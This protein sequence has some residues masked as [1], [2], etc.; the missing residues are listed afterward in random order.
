MADFGVDW[1]LIVVVVVG[2]VGFL[3][4]ALYAVVRAQRSKQPTGAPGL[5]GKEAQVRTA[6]D[7]R[8][9][10]MVHG[11]LWE[12][13]LDEGRAEPEEEVIITEVEGLK[14]KVTRKEKEVS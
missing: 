1:W 6:L 3:V 10:V 7:P 5:I 9:T 8:G 12:A 13:V 4:F 11:E 14:L 2:V